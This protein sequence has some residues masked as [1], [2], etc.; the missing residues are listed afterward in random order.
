[1]AKNDID[2]N[3][4]QQA[5]ERFAAKKQQEMLEGLP[6][7][8]HSIAKKAMDEEEA[9]EYAQAIFFAKQI[10]EKKDECDEKGL[11]AVYGMIARV[12]PE[13]LADDIEDNHKKYDSDLEEFYEFL[14][15]VEMDEG[16]Q[17]LLVN[18]LLRLCDC[19]V[20]DWYR[21]LFLS[22]LEHITK[23]LDPEKYAGTI[24]S[25]YASMESFNFYGDTKVSVLVK[26]AIKNLYDEAFTA[27][28]EKTEIN[29]DELKIDVLL[30]KWNLTQ[31]AE[32]AAG[33]LDYVKES[34]PHSYKLIEETVLAATADRTAAE[35]NL[36]AELMKN[37][38]AGITEEKMA[39]VMN[40]NYEKAKAQEAFPK[41]FVNGKST[42]VRN[43]EKI[44]R[45][46]PC[47]CGSGKKYKNCCGK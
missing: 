42:Y 16:M 33:E 10:L 23:Y 7:S 1:M 38:K 15:S 14:D 13:L 5:N 21:P 39:A 4:I 25:A 22:F 26:N 9:G 18:A 32:T 11:L 41:A 40:S 19:M 37:A 28:E 36:L 2:L 34:Y 8:V 3:R 30:S 35:K 31:Y 20:N 43:G 29:T 45:N 27:K 12:Y 17:M 6:K 47:P 46:D 24:E 44:G